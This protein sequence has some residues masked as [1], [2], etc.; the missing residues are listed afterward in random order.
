MGKSKRNGVENIGRKVRKCCRSAVGYVD[1]NQ[2]KVFVILLGVFLLVLIINVS[3]TTSSSIALSQKAEVIKELNKPSL[4]Q[5]SIIN[6]ENC[7]D[8]S[9]VLESIRGE[10]VEITEE[11]TIDFSS[12]EAK[13]LIEK[14]GIE[15]IPSVLI[16][17]EVDGN[18]NFNDFKLVG[19]AL[20]LENIEPP[21]LDLAGEMRGEVSVIEIT[22]SCEVCI[23]VSSIVDSFKQMGVAITNWE[24]VEYNSVEGRELISKYGVKQSPAVLIS[25]DIDYYEAVSQSLAQLDL[26]KKDG[27]YVLHSVV[28]PYRNLVTNKIEGLIDLIML[29]DESCTGCY[30]VSVNKQILARFGM[31]IGSEKVYDVSSA[32]GEKL[33]LKYNIEKV[34]MIIV[35]P[36]GEA[37][38]S[39]V[40]V[41]SQ[42]GSIEGDGW[43]VMRSPEVIGVVK[44]LSTGQVIGSN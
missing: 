16:F 10:N 38:D 24:K 17:G 37:Y 15:K 41:W 2:N 42:V 26:V 11:R 19:E 35:S 6:C 25:E 40:G 1:K 34:P 9:S 39:F 36:E 5:L 32:E 31:A 21:Y 30:D 13:V 20:V 4:I 33:V 18:V 14:Y 43:F 29:E 3:L 22:D 7:F 12:D 28:P 8:I 23:D 27:Y 44:D